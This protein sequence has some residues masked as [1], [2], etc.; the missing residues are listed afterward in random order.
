MR[1]INLGSATVG[2]SAP[3]YFIAE[4]GS[5]HNGDMDLCRRIIDAAASAGVDAVKFQS[6]TEDDLISE[7][8]YE[9]NTAYTDKKKHFGT[10]R[11]MVRKYRFT[12]DQHREIQLYCEQVGVTF[13]SSVFSKQGADLLDELDVPFYKLAS[14]DI[15]NL[16]LLEYVAEKGRPMI[17][18]TGMATLGEV[19]QAVRT[20]RR[21][22][23]DDLILLHCVSTYPPDVETVNLRNMGML[24]TAFR[25]PVG[26]SDHTL[27]TSIPLAAIARG[28][29][30]V[31]KHF[32]ID[33]DLPG[34]DHAISASPEELDRLVREGYCIFHALGS[35]VRRVGEAEQQKRVQFR[36]SAVAR[37]TLE[38]GSPLTLNEVAFKRPGNGIA[39]DEFKYAIGQ[40]I[41]RP[42][43]KGHVIHWDDLK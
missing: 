42:I 15:N 2:S 11:E 23:N 19:D 3:P 25:V 34:W 5:N 20:I 37:H 1:T 24:R 31:E 6:W 32:T 28:A 18:S 14:M 36:R 26:Y 30:I 27:G 40:T 8:E 41:A 9:R 33:N 13:C 43:E 7:E 12:P 22:G 4:I 39:P 38:K 29:C 10:L 35:S 16:S 21:A 17:V